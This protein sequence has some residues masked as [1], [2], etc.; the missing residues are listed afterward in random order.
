[1]R[2]HVDR[3]GPPP[4]VIATRQRAFVSA[5]PR[6]ENL[7]DTDNFRFDWV[8]SIAVVLT[9]G[10][11][12]KTSFQMLF[13]NDPALIGVPLLD[14]SSLLTGQV[15]IPSQRVDSFLTMSLVIQL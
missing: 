6:D 10:L 8:A 14:L 12:F 9:E 5:I 4:H 2:P 1:M 15:Q 13:D 11:A 3:S 7:Y